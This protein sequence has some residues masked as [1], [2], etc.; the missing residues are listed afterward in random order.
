MSAPVTAFLVGGPRSGEVLAL[1]S[2][3][4]EILVPENV[5]PWAHHAPPKAEDPWKPV[6]L[7][8]HVY[9]RVGPRLSNP[10]LPNSF[11][12]EWIGLEDR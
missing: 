9:R 6:L 2:H 1:R 4:P 12:Y 7:R 10:D 8:V 3:R 5:P 11:V